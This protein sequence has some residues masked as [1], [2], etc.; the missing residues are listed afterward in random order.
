MESPNDTNETDFM[1]SDGMSATEFLWR[2]DIDADKELPVEPPDDTDDIDFMDIDDMTAMEF[3]WRGDVDADKA[4]GINVPPH[5]RIRVMTATG[6]Y[7]TDSGFF[8]AQ[9]VLEPSYEDD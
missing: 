6:D 8:P 1:D 2:G 4:I 9:I 7:T 3:L 5:T